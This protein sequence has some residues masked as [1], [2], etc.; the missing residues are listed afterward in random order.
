MQTPVAIT[1]NWATDASITA[2]VAPATDATIISNVMNVAKTSSI[3]TNS[4]F[5]YL[6]RMGWIKVEKSGHTIDGNGAQ[7][8]NIFKVTGVVELALFGEITAVSNIDVCNDIFFEL[9]DGASSTSITSSMMANALGTRPVG[10][11][12]AKVGSVSSVAIAV[13]SASGSVT[14]PVGMAPGSWVPG[15]L[16]PCIASAKAGADNYV[17]FGFTGNNDTSF[18]MKFTALYRP[19]LSSGTVVSA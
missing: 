3:T 8:D 7:T 19:I 2:N 15:V 11:W 5:D 16:F 1:G 13:S 18:T 10:T 12:V 17:R 9:Y 4:P 14:E 6:A